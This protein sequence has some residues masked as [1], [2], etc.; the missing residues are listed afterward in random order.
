MHMKSNCLKD[1]QNS[2]GKRAMY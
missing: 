1:Y 2:V